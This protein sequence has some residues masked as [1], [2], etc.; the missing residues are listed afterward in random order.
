MDNMDAISYVKA[1][2]GMLVL[3]LAVLAL[4]VALIAVSD[5]SDAT[6][7][8]EMVTIKFDC[9]G[10]TPIADMEVEKGSL[11]AEVL[12]TVSTDKEGYNFLT[13]CPD[14]ELKEF[15]KYNV[16]VTKDMTLYAKWYAANEAVILFLDEESP[17]ISQS[18]IDYKFV[19]IGNALAKP[20]D[21][22]KSGYKFVGWYTSDGEQY[23]FD[24]PVADD[25]IL[26]AVWEES[27]SILGI[28]Q[29]TF[30]WI[31]VGLIAALAIAAIA[32]FFFFG[33]AI[34]M[35]PG[36]AAIVFAIIGFI[37]G[38]FKYL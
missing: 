5:S 6:D 22:V 31:L 14:K 18:M 29:A 3:A 25:L 37:V 23:D 20:S 12:F 9:N 32:V 33:P 10:G 27:G 38:A 1:H 2:A 16:T 7:E 8:P 24:T 11:L 4:P 36:I 15:A 28:D 35:I 19:K 17:M 34:A 13:W 26:L 21:P 30:A